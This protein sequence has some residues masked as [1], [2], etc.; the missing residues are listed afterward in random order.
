MGKNPD[1]GS[2]MN[3][4]DHISESLVGKNLLGLKTPELFDADPDLDRGTGI[5]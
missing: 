3:I 2:G 1:R 5:L 4:P